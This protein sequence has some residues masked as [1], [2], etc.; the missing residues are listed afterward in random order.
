MNA[1]PVDWSDL[2]LLVSVSGAGSMLRAGRRL[3]LAASTVSR[4]MSQLERAVGTPLLERGPAGVRLTAAGLALADCG[5][6]LGFGVAR[7]LR[8]L[9][10]PDAHLTG[11][12]RISAGDGF[13][14]PIVAAMRA[15]AA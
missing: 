2:Q 13:V 10:R 1:Q 6:E 8:E 9:P 12:V 5:I 3:G 11:V 4:R 7:A 15:M 14:D